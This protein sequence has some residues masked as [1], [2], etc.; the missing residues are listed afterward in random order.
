MIE[1]H[2]DEE[3]RVPY[4]NPP[5]L[6]DRLTE[7][8]KRIPAGEYGVICIPM[9]VTV[10]CPEALYVSNCKTA[11]LEA[12]RRSRIAGELTSDGK[13]IVRPELFDTRLYAVYDSAGVQ[14]AL[15]TNGERYE[16]R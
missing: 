2:Q 15:F 11:H 6:Q 8:I 4:Q 5:S 1:E 10:Q 7:Q 3:Q 14:V 9:Q 12:E 13:S 16:R